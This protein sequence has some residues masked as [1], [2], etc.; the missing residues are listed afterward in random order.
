MTAVS[1]SALTRVRHLCLALPDTTERTS[2]GAPSFFVGRRRM[3]LSF[4]DNHH[5]DGR[6]GIW[7]AAPPGAQQALVSTAPAS[8]YV[9]AYVGHLGWIGLRLD[10]DVSWQEIAGVI[11]DA[12]LTRAPPTSI[13]KASPSR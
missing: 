12:W 1:D 5:G 6:L 13:A 11:E 4:H 8:Y 10:R 2:N 3:F 7:C 9:P